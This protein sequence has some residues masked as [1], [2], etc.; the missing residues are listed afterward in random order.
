MISVLRVSANDPVIVTSAL[1]VAAAHRRPPLPYLV[2]DLPQPHVFLADPQTR[3]EELEDLSQRVLPAEGRR[4][5]EVL[6]G[7][8]GLTGPTEA[9]RCA[10]TTHTQ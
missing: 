9:G 5:G 7:R 1:T 10:Y 2:L 8:D 6:T 3:H 4:V